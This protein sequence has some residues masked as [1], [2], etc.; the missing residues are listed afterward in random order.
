MSVS[1]LMSH[2]AVIWMGYELHDQWMTE[3]IE[4]TWGNVVMSLINKPFGD[5]GCLSEARE[6]RR[7]T[8]T[9]HFDQP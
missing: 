4:M 7:S 8:T 9:A 3:D 2:V 5:W 1:C 6:S